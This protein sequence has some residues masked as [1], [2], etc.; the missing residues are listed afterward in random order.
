MKN[1]IITYLSPVD[2]NVVVWGIFETESEAIKLASDLEYDDV[3]VYAA[4][5]IFKLTACK[6]NESEGVK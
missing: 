4:E 6:Q 5:R 3:R 1:Y 2:A